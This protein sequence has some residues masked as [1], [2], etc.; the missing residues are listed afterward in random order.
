MI[1]MAIINGV[2]KSAQMLSNSL[3]TNELWI[4][5]SKFPVSTVTTDG[6]ALFG[7]WTSA[8]T[9]MTKFV[10]HILGLV[11]RKQISRAGTSNYIPQILWDVITCPCPW[12]LILVHQSSYMYICIW[13]YLLIVANIKYN[14]FLSYITCKGLYFQFT[15]HVAVIVS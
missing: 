13:Y 10:Y 15:H 14:L 1:S 8:G 3:I 7:T 9:T 4:L 5:L 2:I 6:L 11:C 12:Y